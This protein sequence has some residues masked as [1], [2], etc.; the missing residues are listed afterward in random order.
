[1]MQNQKE[2]H[3]YS[4]ANNLNAKV[5]RRDQLMEQVATKKT[6]YSL[7]K[8]DYVGHRTVGHSRCYVACDRVGYSGLYI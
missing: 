3:R 4:E 2:A 6:T 7:N 5:H 8:V 1:M